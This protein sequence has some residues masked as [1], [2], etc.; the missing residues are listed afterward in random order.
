[1]KRLLSIVTIT[2]GVIVTQGFAQDIV[3]GPPTGT[4]LTPVMGYGAGGPHPGPFDGREL[5][6]AAEI[7]DGP[8]ALLF[9]HEITRNILPV[10]RGLDI[11]ANRFAIKSFKSFTLLLHADRSEAESRL[12]AVNGS[13]KLR[14]PMLLS[15]DGA[16]GPGNY[17]LNR[18]A[19]LSLILVNHGKV[20]RSVALT[21]VNQED[22]GK[23]SE[24]VEELTG[25]IPSNPA[26]LRGLVEAGLPKDTESLRKL[27]LDQGVQIQAL[28]AQ[29]QR[30]QNRTAGMQPNRMT[31]ERRDPPRARAAR[32][33]AP[34]RRDGTPEAAQERPTT[35]A[36]TPPPVQV[37]QGKPPEDPELNS[38]LRSFIRKTHDAAQVDAIFAD[39]QKRAKV[40]DDL[41]TEAVEMFKLMLSFRERYGTDHAQELAEGFL[42]AHGTSR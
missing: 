19:T 32:P 7:G 26:E 13:L 9:V 35:D 29:L 37:R 38:L 33:G 6:V 36:T 30:V 39:I 2:I 20:V 21:D 16:E 8:G 17:A 1:M 41:T 12:K 31:P 5:D 23:L 10:V 40:N 18:K 24:W 28:Y 3:T 15:L 11:T 22:V 25:P 34:G 14:N 42:K 4:A 27:A